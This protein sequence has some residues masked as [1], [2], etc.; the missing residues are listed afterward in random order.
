MQHVAEITAKPEFKDLHAKL[1]R[2]ERRSRV[3]AFLLVLPLLCFLLLAFAVPITWIL[4]NSL[5]NPGIYD[6]MPNFYSALQADQTNVPGEAVFQA[7][8]DDMAAGRKAGGLP[9]ALKPLRH[10]DRRVWRLFSKTSKKIPEIFDGSA[11]EWFLSYK[12]DWGKPKTWTIAR[13]VAKPFT[14]FYFIHALDLH[15]KVTGDLVFKDKDE[16]VYL[17]VLINTFEISFF[18]TLFTFLLGYPLAYWI[19]NMENWKANILM[20]CVLLPFWTSFLV[21]TYVW[22]LILQSEG[23]LNSSMLAIGLI[24]NPLSLIHNRFSV[25]V[26]MTH[27][28]LPFMV[29]PIYSVMKSIP[30]E[31]V[32]AAVSLGAHPLYAFR[33][34]YFPQTLHGVGAGGFLVF[35]VALGY[36]ITPALV[37]GAKDTMISMIIADNI[38]V[39][40]N[41]GMAG[42]LGVILLVATLT[43]YFLY[44]RIMGLEDLRIN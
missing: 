24:E 41:W 6:G 43:I 29:L 38:N 1:L 36:Y 11:K 34:I 22:I 25:Y 15:H 44:A 19:A 23:P 30:Q 31:H 3:R 40:L 21:R 13:R 16:R 4:V 17:G 37:G 39:L 26:A 7:L 42:A 14:P 28:L 33:R 9:R 5:Y 18:V 20:V 12:P 32:K 2:A 10:Q 8:A 35:I 27:V